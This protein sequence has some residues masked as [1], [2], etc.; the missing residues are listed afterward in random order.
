MADELRPFVGLCCLFQLRGGDQFIAPLEHCQ[1]N[2]TGYK[3][4]SMGYSWTED[5]CYHLNDETSDYD[6]MKIS[7]AATSISELASDAGV[8]KLRESRATQTVSIDVDRWD[9][10][11]GTLTDL[12]DEINELRAKNA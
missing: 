2:I 10:L 1:P 12:I 4:Q 5:G 3:Y 7:I 9:R 8:L 6:L 11:V